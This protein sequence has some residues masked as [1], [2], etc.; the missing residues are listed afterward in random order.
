MILA[1]GSSLLSWKS[2]ESS[3]GEVSE[4]SVNSILSNCKLCGRVSLLAKVMPFKNVSMTELILVELLFPLPY[5]VHLLFL[6][7]TLRLVLRFLFSV[8]HRTKYV[9]GNLTKE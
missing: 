7:S 5:K 4:M 3:Q 8:L 2:Q 6:T 9:E 1:C